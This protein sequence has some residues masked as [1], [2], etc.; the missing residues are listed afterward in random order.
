MTDTMTVYNTV[1]QTMTEVRLE[2]F[3][4]FL[5]CI[6]DMNLLTIDDDCAYNYHSIKH[7]HQDY[8]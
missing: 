5:L 6:T 8:D 1:T 3:V 7:G 2:S 4:S